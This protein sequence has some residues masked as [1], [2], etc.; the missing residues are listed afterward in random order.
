MTPQSL[1]S[2]VVKS[3]AL[4]DRSKILEPCFGNGSFLVVI[5]EALLVQGNGSR[6]EKLRRIFIEQL[7]GV[8]MDE[9][10]YRQAIEVLEARYGQLPKGHH[11][12]QN[13]FFLEAYQPAFFDYVIGNPPFGGTF[14]PEIEDQ[15]DRQYGFWGSY[16]VKKETYCFF[17][18]RSLDLL[19]IGG[20]LR[21]ISSDTFMTINTMQGLRRRLMD[22]CTN[23]VVSLKRFSAETSYPMVVL[24]ATKLGASD[25]ITVNGRHVARA[26]IELTGNFSWSVD[27]ALIP[28]FRGDTLSNYVTCTSGMTVGKNEYF[29]RRL[30][31]DGTFY[32]PYQFT[33]YDKPTTL[34]EEL[35]K[36]RLGKI[37]PAKQ[38]AI[39][40]QEAQGLTYRAIRITKRKR[41]AKEHYPHSDY[42]P[43]NKASKAIVFAPLQHIIFWKNQGE[44]VLTYKKTG[45]W[46]LRGVGGQ[47][48]FMREGLTWQLIASRINMRYLP[49]GYILDSGAPCAFLKPGIDADELWF[50]LGWTLTDLATHILKTVINHTKNIQ[51]K[52]IERLP[53]PWWIDHKKKL[54][55][56]RLVHKLVE[57][58]KKG[59]LVQRDDSRILELNRLFAIDSGL[60]KTV[61]PQ[62]SADAT[63]PGQSQPNVN[64]Q[65]IFS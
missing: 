24:T 42:V 57:G 34:A 64:Q 8:E 27:E 6:T 37:S 11:L 3:L 56:I 28:Y 29:V 43:Y 58:A 21:F 40:E 51:G 46:Y 13:D 26:D 60:L 47:G 16:K 45:N 9:D 53:Y 12:H 22:Q 4:D 10:L 5:I 55:V 50:I 41:P 23:D 30:E 7:Y 2:E 14:N 39:R 32:E 15:L 25:K 36:A 33:Y 65:F 61:V 35:T 62:S 48:Y 18:A 54:R 19:K 59:Q 20:V 52:D 17:I 38:A 1:S 63:S 49:S 44:A 31:A